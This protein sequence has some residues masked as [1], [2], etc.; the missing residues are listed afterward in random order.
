M[1]VK[2]SRWW[3]AAL[4]CLTLW[5]A[6][7][8]AQTDSWENRNA[9]GKV[10]YEQGDYAEAE[11]HFAAALKIAEAFGANDPRLGTTLNNL[12]ELY[13]DQ[14]RYGE[15]EPLYKRALAIREKALGPEH[16]DVATSLDD[17]APV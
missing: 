12:A 9:A 2:G 13:Q 10:A 3:F 6:P 11:R 17:L 5:S 1:T 15:A 4:L 14:G 16:P 8:L 7:A